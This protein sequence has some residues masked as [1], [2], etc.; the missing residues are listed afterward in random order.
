MKWLPFQNH[1]L[2]YDVKLNVN[3]KSPI[4]AINNIKSQI[5]T[6]AY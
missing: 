5:I 1:F 6:F 4:I 2:L 3:N